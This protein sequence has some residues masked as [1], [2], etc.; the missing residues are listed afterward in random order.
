MAPTFAFEKGTQRY[1]YTS[2][3]RKGQFV[4]YE[5]VHQLTNDYQSQQRAAGQKILD[6]LI[7][8]KISTADW[9]TET[10]SHLRPAHINMYALGF[11]GHARLDAAEYGAIGA[12]LKTEYGYL[13]QF[14]Q[15]INA[16]ELSE[17][18]I[19]ARLDLYYESTWATY[20]RARERSHKREGYQWEK[21]FLAAGGK[22]CAD[23]VTYADRGWV[24]IGDLPTPGTDC[25]CKSRCRC[26]KEFDS[27][28]GQPTHSLLDRR[29]GWLNANTSKPDVSQMSAMV[30]TEIDERTAEPRVETEVEGFYWGNPD[31]ADL[32][33]IKAHT[34]FDWDASEWYMVPMLASDNLIW[35]SWSCSWHRS[36]LGMMVDQYPGQ[37]LMVDHD[38][39]SIEGTKGFFVR[40]V[41]MQQA[42]APKN[43]I[44]ALGNTQLNK[45]IL[46]KD[47]WLQVYLQAAIPTTEEGLIQSLKRRQIEDVSTG[48]I[49]NGQEYICPHC[50]ARLGR[51]VPFSERGEDGKFTCPHEIPDPFLKMAVEFGWF[52]DE[53]VLFADYALMRGQGGERHFETSFVGVGNL[54]AAQVLRPKG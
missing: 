47:G 37:S 45:A 9:L 50:S 52:G 17:A 20:E 48:S 15:A 35:S 18:Q 40:S 30:E 54:P 49:L 23:C 2:G 19:R 38:S 41:L 34:G 8:Q 46:K 29:H 36:V 42:I 43:I 27:A 44:D 32:K 21:R 24:P 25:A 1:R 11:G 28:D 3:D 5:A 16:G 12:R 39:Y 22:P 33:E 14:A 4:S 10:A 13:R 51:D 26:W 31:D 53:E 6:K 7:D